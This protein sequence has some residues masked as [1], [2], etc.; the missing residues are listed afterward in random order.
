MDRGTKSC[1]SFQDSLSNEGIQS[2]R[3]PPRAS[4]MNALVERFFSPLNSECLN[5]RIVFGER[6]FCNAVQKYLSYC[7]LDR[8]KGLGNQPI[9]PNDRPPNTD[10][11]MITTEH[12]G[13]M[14]RSYRRAA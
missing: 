1:E 11:E 2:I 9:V 10:A 6:S 4:H 12:L 8:P 7:H 14:L 5:K 13:G 3:L